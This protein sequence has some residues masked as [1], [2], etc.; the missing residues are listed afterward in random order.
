[1]KVLSVC[2]NAFLLL[3][4]VDGGSVQFNPIENLFSGIFLQT[5]QESTNTTTTGRLFPDPHAPTPEEREAERVSRRERMRERNERVKE[6]IKYI[7]PDTVERVSDE[8]FERIQDEH[9]SLR[10]LGWAQ[11]NDKTIKYADPGEDYD[12]WSQAYRM[13]GAFIDCDHKIEQGGSH[14]NN[15]NND[16]DDQS[17]SRW[18]LWASVSDADIM[19]FCV[20]IVFCGGYSHLLLFPIPQYVDPNYKGNGYYEYFGDNPSGVLDCH[21]PDTDWV[22]LGIYRQE[23]YQFIEQISKHLWAIDEYEYV[24]AVAGLA[25]MT[26][27]DC[28]YVGQTSKGESIYAGVAPKRYGNFEM[29]LYTDGYCLTPNEKTGYTFD[30][31]GLYSDVQLG[32]NNKN[33]NDGNNNNQNS[34]SWAT[35]WW[36][37]TQEYTFTQ[38]NDVYEDFKYCTSCIDYPTYQDGYVIGDTGM[39]DD[40]LINQCWKFYSHDSYPCESDC[41]ALAAAQ[42]T[43]LSVN[44]AGKIYGEAM[45]GF[46]RT[47]SRAA[48]TGT[49]SQFSRLLS[50]VFVTFSFIVFV[51][52]F[53][54]FAVARRSRYRE[55]RSSKSRRLLD[56]DG[57]RPSRKRSKSRN[58]DEGDGIFRT[59]GRRSSRSKSKSRSRLDKQDDYESPKS[60]RRHRSRGRKDDF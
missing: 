51:A 52:T 36:Q 43:I 5:G 29:A 38:L 20:K 22:L 13:L 16:G 17:C 19:K 28:F 31:F 1:M 3:K 53:L 15:N 50:N 39:D 9:P 35:E 27:A 10:K 14:D 6:A 48:A 32:K 33:N 45:A 21:K 57:G 8:D 41:I 11:W 47:T 40:D 34:Y 60:S 12:M 55:S 18:M 2:L 25:Y 4:T 37:D 30:S 26:N 56:D 49:E 7:R 23:F 42:G 59:S 44:T 58:A 54:A 46:Y 24:V